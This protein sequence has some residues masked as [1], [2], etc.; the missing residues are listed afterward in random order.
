MSASVA[1]VGETG[2]Y[3]QNAVVRARNIFGKL[4]LPDSE[5]DHRRVLAVLT[6]VDAPYEAPTNPAAVIRTH[7]Q[8][9]DE[10]VAELHAVLKARGLA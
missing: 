10:S 3:V 8:S 7:E 1:F 5:N 6:G 9:L 2:P 4:E